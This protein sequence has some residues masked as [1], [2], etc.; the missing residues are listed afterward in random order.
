[1]RRPGAPRA[2]RSP[3]PSSVARRSMP[4]AEPMV[5]LLGEPAVSQ[6]ATFILQT[7][8]ERDPSGRG[9]A[10]LRA[11]LTSEVRKAAATLLAGCLARREDG[12]AVAAL[13]GNADPVVQLGAITGL[14]N[15]AVPRAQQDAVVAALTAVLADAEL[16]VRKE[17]IW[18]LYLLGSEGAAL[19]AAVPALE[20]AVE[21]QATQGNA[22][23]ALSLAWNASNDAR[24]HELA[25]S[26]SGVVQLG[27]AWG[28]ADVRLRRGD[29]AAL[30]AMFADDNANVR[31]G[32]GAFLYDAK[33]R[34]R[35]ISLAA[36]AFT[37]LER[38]HP[39]DAM[40]HARIFA[41]REI[42]ERGPD[43]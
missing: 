28:A 15:G 31:R 29:L 37:E 27:A 35:D 19:D 9:A 40:L 39:D 1:M 20:R 6:L 42:V 14:A 3:M 25:A 16:A 17:A 12:A 22:A 30:K 18:A 2:R 13:I 23:I 36:Q 21:E 43:G 33:R 34:G 38:D 7:D 26:V 24:A 4:A 32:L 5:A 41:V 11:A 10:A 8:V